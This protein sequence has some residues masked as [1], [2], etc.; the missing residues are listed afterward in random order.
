[1]PNADLR[2]WPEPL[3]MLDDFGAFTKTVGDFL[4]DSG[5]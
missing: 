4:G 3:A 5:S 1:M 2:I